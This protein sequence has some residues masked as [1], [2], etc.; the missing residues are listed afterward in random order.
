MASRVI[1]FEI[2]AS[3]TKV[4]ELDY[5]GKSHKVYN[6]FR[7][8][9]PEGV[10]RD[11]TLDPKPEFISAI[12]SEMARRRV[13]AKQ[14]IFTV[15]SSKIAIRDIEVPMAKDNRLLDLVKA[16]APEYFPVDL[17]DYALAYTK[18]GTVGEGPQQRY[19][20]QV[21][22]MPNAMLVGYYNFAKALKLEVIGLDYAGNSVYQLAKDT[23]KEGSNLIVKVEGHNTLVMAIKDQKIALTRN[24]GYGITESL[25]LVKETS[26]WGACEDILQALQIME[27][28]MCLN[29][30]E[31]EKE[32]EEAPASAPADN[33]GL[34]ILNLDDDSDNKEDTPKKR[35]TEEERAAQ[36]AAAMYAD[37]EPKE[38]KKP[39]NHRDKTKEEITEALEMVVNGVSRVMDF[40][41][42]SNDGASIDKILL[43][44]LGA[45]VQGFREMLEI[46]TGK[47]VELFK[48]TEGLNLEKLFD[49]KS[50]GEYLTCVGATINPVGFKKEEEKKTKAEA[51]K[52]GAFAGVDPIII[53][54]A[55]LAIS[56]IAGGVMLGLSLPNYFNAKSTN[57][58]LT[59]QYNELLPAVDTYNTYVTAKLAYNEATAMYEAT[60]NPNDELNLF[61]EELEKKMPSSGFVQAFSADPTTVTISVV[62][63]SKDEAASMIEML[64]TFDSLYPDTVTV[65]GLTSELDEEGNVVA[66][67]FTVSGMYAD[68]TDEADE[69]VIEEEAE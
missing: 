64:R 69:E 26:A 15:N 5:K 18:L 41:E 50:Y 40:Y 36:Y 65:S 21:L 14:V 20:L 39:L 59:A 37:D 30:P 25:N 2:G 33:S 31:P 43:M 1:S 54:V 35:P 42:H 22:A 32:E 27:K 61:L 47:P 52:G 29:L 3:L 38:E 66:V 46:L 51:G 48:K 49:S 8:K 53:G 11:G 57:N 55:V 13:A 28:N 68:K 17:T 7:I 45:D 56:V 34:D 23:C 67:D 58:R 16:K 10:T 4:C 24:V 62:V 19:K 6:Y 9:T 12:Q 44:G 60:E 63:P